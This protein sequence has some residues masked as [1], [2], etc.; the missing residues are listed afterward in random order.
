MS[1]AL[2]AHRT[3]R[4]TIRS[5]ALDLSGEEKLTLGVLL[6]RTITNDRNPSSLRVRTMKDILAKLDAKSPVQPDPVPKPHRIRGYSV[7]GS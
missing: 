5:K 2:Q 4:Q 3:R 7:G 6:T 1:P